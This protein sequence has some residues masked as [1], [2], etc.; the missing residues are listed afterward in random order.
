MI[1]CGGFG[2]LHLFQ[3]VDFEKIKIKILE[4]A[5]TFLGVN[6]K[7]LG[8]PISLEDFQKQR[9]GKY[10]LEIKLLF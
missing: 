1:V 2:R 4:N 6:I 9:F 10:R 8:Q 5:A 3:A 7:V